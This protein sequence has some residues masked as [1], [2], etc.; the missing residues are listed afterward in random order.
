MEWPILAS[1]KEFPFKNSSSAMFPTEEADPT[2]NRPLLKSHFRSSEANVTVAE[3]SAE[4]DE[5]DEVDEVVMEVISIR[6]TRETKRRVNIMEIAV[7]G[8]NTV[9]NTIT[10]AIMTGTVE[11]SMERSS[12]AVNTMVATT[13][14]TARPIEG[15]EVEGEDTRSSTAATATEVDLT[16]NNDAPL[17]GWC[18]VK[19]TMCSQI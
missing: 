2:S 15:V 14:G 10:V 7:E 12:T 3:I 8:H 1:F 5:V 19:E 6:E 4:V 9:L 17:R 16:T 13:T 18:P 11:L